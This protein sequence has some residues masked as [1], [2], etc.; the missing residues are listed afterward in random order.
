MAVLDLLPKGDIQVL[1]PRD[2][3]APSSYELDVGGTMDLGCYLITSEAGYEVLKLFATRTP[4][5]F[6]AMF[7]TRGS[8]GA[9]GD[10]SALAAA[11][12]ATFTATRS[13]EITQPEGAATTRSVLIR[14]APN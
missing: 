3:E 11:L 2:E 1:R 5:D 6:R 7:E 4:Q 14:V 13:D 8:R 9:T 12:A 10:L